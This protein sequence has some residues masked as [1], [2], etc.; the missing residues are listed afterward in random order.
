DLA[1][2]LHQPADLDHRGVH[3]VGRGGGHRLDPDR[4][5]ASDTDVAE[6]NL[7]RD[8]PSVMGVQCELAHRAD[9]SL[10]PSAATTNPGNPGSSALRPRRFLAPGVRVW[11]KTSLNGINNS[12]Q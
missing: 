6:E 2:R 4:I 9:S 11:G 8:S 3:V 10:A 1:P 5:V 12:F 7:A